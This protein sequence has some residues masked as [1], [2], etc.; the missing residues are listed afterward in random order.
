LDALFVL[1]PQE[2][3]LRLQDLVTPPASSCNFASPWSR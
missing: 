3:S 2:L 1:G